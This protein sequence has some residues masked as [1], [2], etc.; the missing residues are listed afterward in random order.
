[1]A[2]EVI[3]GLLAIIAVLLFLCWVAVRGMWGEIRSLSMTVDSF[4]YE[5]KRLNNYEERRKYSDEAMIDR[6]SGGGQ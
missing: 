5:Y 2:S 4:L 3:V 1:M 6:H